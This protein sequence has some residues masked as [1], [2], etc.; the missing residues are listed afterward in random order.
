MG[1]WK[2]KEPMTNSDLPPRR[3]VRQPTEKKKKKH[4][5]DKIPQKL[6]PS[7]D[8]ETVEKTPPLSSKKDLNERGREN[9]PK[10]GHET[11]APA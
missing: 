5:G 2:K 10:R 11:A 4:W 3:E 9:L 6:T 8:K 1:I 7:R